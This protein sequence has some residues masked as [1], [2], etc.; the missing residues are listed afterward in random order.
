MELL[1]DLYTA[2]TFVVKTR[3]LTLRSRQSWF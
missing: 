1:T 2:A 3:M